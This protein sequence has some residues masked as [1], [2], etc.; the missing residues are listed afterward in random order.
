[1]AEALWLLPM[2]K[3]A[4]YMTLEKLTKYVF[5]AILVGA[6][7]STFAVSL[8]RMRGTAIVGRPFDVTLVARLGDDEQ[9]STLCFDAEVSFGDDLISPARVNTSLAAGGNAREVLVRVRTS[10]AVDE[11]VVTVNVREGCL[12]KN[13]RKYVFLA[14]VLTGNAA[15]LTVSNGEVAGPAS[16]Q[17]PVPGGHG[18]G[19]SRAERVADAAVAPS[20]F[21]RKRVPPRPGNSRPAKSPHKAVNGMSGMSARV[22]AKRALDS[23]GKS[24]RSRLKLDLLELAA[25]RDPVLRAS[26]ELLTQPSAAPQPRTRKATLWQ[27]L[28]AQPQEVLRDGQRLKTLEDDVA[29]MLEQSRL[30]DKAVSD[31]RV[32]LDQSRGER[33]SNW[34]VYALA[35][36]LL[37]SWVTAAYLWSGN[38]REYGA[39]NGSPWWRKGSGADGGRALGV[40]PEELSD[41][42]RH[43]RHAPAGA[44]AS[45]KFTP[46]YTHEEEPLRDFTLGEADVPSAHRFKTLEPV[47]AR[48]SV[49]F[50]ISLPS[51][52]GMPPRIVNAEEL[53]DVQQQADFFVSLGDV[54][55][56]VGVLR[57]HIAD[58]EETSALAYLDLFD[59]YHQLGRKADYQTLSEDFS[60]TFN[61]RVPAFESYK[62]V[63]QGLES[64]EA[65][66]SRI[67]A[68]WPTPKVLEVIEESIFLKPDSRN[69][70][71]SLA[72]YRELLLLHAIAK[73]VVTPSASPKSS[74]YSAVAQPAL[75]GF[76][77]TSIQPLSA[78]L[79]ELPILPDTSGPTQPLATPHVGVDIDLNFDSDDFQGKP[80]AAP[81]RLRDHGM[82]ACFT[83]DS[84]EFDA[85]TMESP[86]R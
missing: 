39:K 18:G 52:T 36:S 82:P 31:L 1:M 83:H 66:L 84:L 20:G 79:Q 48:D 76:A 74:V 14:E 72:A 11:P 7:I 30:T 25:E 33:F 38:R 60:R 56:A 4:R 3:F 27:A 55:K 45:G 35:A 23:A 21:L 58:S 10:S 53:F 19:A 43:G 42:M 47:A 2:A 61:A 85:F 62:A 63:T 81:V 69:E 17:R 54:D 50:S 40:D 44:P 6:S 37:L 26:S 29:R 34:L 5:G 51:M 64:H 12:Q 65:V 49:E 73:K 57:H 16:M 32:Q 8:G 41:V 15:D 28:N 70:V 68:L 75:S 59:L 9:L 13:T 71:F 22:A 78:Q 77:N 46:D 67:V 86:S 80:D 24:S